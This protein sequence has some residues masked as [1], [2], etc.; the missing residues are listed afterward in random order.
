MI[1]IHLNGHVDPHF[2]GLS[3]ELTVDYGLLIQLLRNDRYDKGFDWTHNRMV[4]SE[5]EDISDWR[6]CLTDCNCGKFINCRVT[7]FPV[8]FWLFRYEN[9]L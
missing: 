2:D 3:H 5:L 7:S 1:G 4:E 6:W 8:L 9:H